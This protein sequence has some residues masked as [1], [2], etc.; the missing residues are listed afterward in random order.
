MA[1]ISR[2][3]KSDM[4]LFAVNIASFQD[5]R[6]PVID[7]VWE[8]DILAKKISPSWQISNNKVEPIGQ[9]SWLFRDGK[10]QYATDNLQQAARF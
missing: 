5:S 7:S 1:S 3:Q 9:V 4:V 2:F 6:F 10:K 8:S